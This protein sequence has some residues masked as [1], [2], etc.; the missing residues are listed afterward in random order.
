MEYYG[1]EA[2]VMGFELRQ[3]FAG[4]FHG[5]NLAYTVATLTLAVALGFFVFSRLMPPGTGGDGEDE[6]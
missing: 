5:K 6:E 2:N 1:G 4:L 3:W